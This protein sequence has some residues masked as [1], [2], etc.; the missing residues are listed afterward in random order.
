MRMQQEST[1]KRGSWSR[2]SCGPN[3]TTDGIFVAQS[4]GMPAL[5]KPYVMVEMPSSSKEQ[6]YDWTNNAEE[7]EF[8]T[9]E[10]PGELNMVSTG[11]LVFNMISLVLLLGCVMAFVV[12]SKGYMLVWITQHSRYRSAAPVAVRK[13]Y[14]RSSSRRILWPAREASTANMHQRSFSIR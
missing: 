13:D 12:T 9:I 14:A 8:Q 4:G 7:K 10:G 3:V 11:R 1:P 6:T 2:G 5:G